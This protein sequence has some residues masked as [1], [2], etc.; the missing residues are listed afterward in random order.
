LGTAQ[1][2]KLGPM[3]LHYSWV[4]YS[5][6]TA[7]GQHPLRQQARPIVSA[8]NKREVNSAENQAIP[9]K[10]LVIFNNVT[11]FCSLIFSIVD[12]QNCNTNL[13]REVSRI[14]LQHFVT[15]IRN[16]FRAMP[17]ATFV[18]RLC[19]SFYMTASPPTEGAQGGGPIDKL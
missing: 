13:K 14:F 18:H 3:S 2:S 5:L 6:E 4:H 17:G 12:N 11:L 9:R 16:L 8:K 10:T 7:D 19:T 15:T 1:L